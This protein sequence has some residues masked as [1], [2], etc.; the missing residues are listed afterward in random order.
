MRKLVILAALAAIAAV[1]ALATPA[2]AQAQTSPA[3]TLRA[4]F[5]SC[6]NERQADPVAF[7]RQHGVGFWRFSPLVRCVLVR[8]RGS[9]STPAPPA[10]PAPTPPAP[11][12]PAPTPPP[13]APTPPPPPPPAEDF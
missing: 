5:T 11:A 1:A 10:P 2:P 3:L 12:P 13:P 8:L 4:A 6:L 7:R 9:G